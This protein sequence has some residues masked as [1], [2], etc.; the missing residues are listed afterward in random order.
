MNTM[1]NN[2]RN[3]FDCVSTNTRD[4][5]YVVETIQTAYFKD[6]LYSKLLKSP[7]SDHNANNGISIFFSFFFNAIQ[8]AACACCSGR[9]KCVCFISL[10]N[11]DTM[12]YIVV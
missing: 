4:T 5:R 12:R 10:W 7:L 9:V 2:E 3:V 1:N 6:V 11:D 8:P